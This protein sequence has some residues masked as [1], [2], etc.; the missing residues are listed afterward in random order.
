MPG[1]RRVRRERQADLPEPGPAVVRLRKDRHVRQ[2]PAQQGVSGGVAAGGDAQA[3][4][5]QLRPGPRQRHRHRRRRAR[6]QQRLLRP[7]AAGDQHVPLPGRQLGPVRLQPGFEVVGEGEVQVVAAEDQVLPDRDPVEADLLVSRP[8]LH[9]DQGEVA[10]APADVADQHVRVRPHAVLPVRGVPG[11]PGVEG[12]LG[13]LDR[14][15]PRQAGGAGGFDGQLPGDLVEARRQRQD[16]VLP[17][18]REP[19]VGGVPRRPQVAQQGGARGDRGEPVDALRGVPGQQRGGA[20][21]AG[22]AEPGLG[23]GDHPPRHPRPVV[24]GERPGDP[25]GFVAPRRVERPR[26]ELPPRRPVE[27][28]RQVLPP[29]DRPGG[30][31]LRDRPR[32]DR[33][34]GF[35]VDVGEGAVRRA[36]VDPHDVTGRGGGVRCGGDRGGVRHGSAMIRRRGFRTTHAP[37]EPEPWLR[38]RREFLRTPAGCRTSGRP[39]SVGTGTAGGRRIASAPATRACRG[40]GH[41]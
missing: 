17:R 8:G 31:E 23:A 38:L 3:P 18:Q 32:L 11:E 19:R 34:A 22:V 10:G 40:R 21:H 35:G 14:D 15:D 4:A 36:Q 33:V 37:P 16:H 2:E 9:A 6:P 26:G 25:V 5:Q 41:R 1:D 24:P 29:L 12:G 13:L 20:V 39:R 27:E 7:P 30:D 28:R